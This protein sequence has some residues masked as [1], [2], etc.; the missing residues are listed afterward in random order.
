MRL[1]P[2]LLLPSL[3]CILVT[4]PCNNCFCFVDRDLALN[5]EPPL[6]L[7][8]AWRARHTLTLLTPLSLIL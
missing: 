7:A 4:R 3:P 1:L 6:S 8:M 2:P 5:T